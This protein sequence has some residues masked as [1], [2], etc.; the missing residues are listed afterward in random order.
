MDSIVSDKKTPD[1]RRMVAIPITIE[2]VAY[3]EEHTFLEQMTL[4]GG[5]LDVLRE[6]H[7]KAIVEVLDLDDRLAKT[8]QGW[9][10]ILVE[11]AK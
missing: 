7:N 9:Q 8:Q 4:V 1:G 3:T 2:F 6:M 11:R 5:N 10:T